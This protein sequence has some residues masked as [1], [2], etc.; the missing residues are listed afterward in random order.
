MPPKLISGKMTSGTF[1]GVPWTGAIVRV[2]RGDAV[3]ENTEARAGLI[4]L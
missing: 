2:P 4:A 3:R 1:T